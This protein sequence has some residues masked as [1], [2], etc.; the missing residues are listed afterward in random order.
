MQSAIFVLQI[1]KF[2]KKSAEKKE[3]RETRKKKRRRAVPL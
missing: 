3:K 1:K 2:G